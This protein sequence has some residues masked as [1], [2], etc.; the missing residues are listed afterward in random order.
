[1]KRNIVWEEILIAGLARL[2]PSLGEIIADSEH[3]VAVRV[4]DI[5]P[6]HWESEIAER[7]IADGKK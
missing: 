4:R 6:S 7:E 3:P 2:I 1:M 5:R